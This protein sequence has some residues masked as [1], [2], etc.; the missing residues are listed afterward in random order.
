MGNVLGDGEIVGRSDPDGAPP[1][2]ENLKLGIDMSHARL[3]EPSSQ[4]LM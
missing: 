3:F 1:H 4:R 2:G